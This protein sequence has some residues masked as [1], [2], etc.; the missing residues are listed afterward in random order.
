MPAG[1]GGGGAPGRDVVPRGALIV[2]ASLPLRGVERPRALEVLRGARRALARARGRAG[3]LAVRLVVLD[4]T[5]PGV[6]RWAPEVVAANARRAV[7]DRH[8]IAYLGEGDTAASTVSVPLLNEEGILQVTPTDTFAGLTEAE[9]PVPGG[10][11]RFYPNPL[12]KRGFGRVI[13]D[14]VAQARALV[15]WM[16]RLG[17]RRLTVVRDDSLYASSLAAQ[18]ARDAVARGLSVAPELRADLD[19][20]DLS[21]LEARVR[22]SRPGAVF[23][24]TVA[25]APA[26]R[27]WRALHEAVP[28]ARLFGPG[29]LALPAFTAALGPAAPAT[30]L[31]GPSSRLGTGA[32]P[33]RDYGEA[34]MA[35]ILD[36]IRR[37]GPHGRSRR[38]VVAAFLAAPRPGAPGGFS[39]YRVEQGRLRL[40]ARL[41][42]QR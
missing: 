22:A 33:W 35:T 21:G 31:S 8:T 30:Y 4:D 37:A 13:P 40:A 42:G 1:C 5:P 38:A 20:A 32:G 16:M 7:H 28:G 19:A 11:A 9:G 27:L 41:T 23:F 34:A 3:P 39:G 29:A 14:D 17:V 26:A 6:E 25:V 12:V 18:V 2:Y 15:G 36:A 10:P 24:P